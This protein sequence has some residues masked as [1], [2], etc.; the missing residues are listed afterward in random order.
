MIIALGLPLADPAHLEC[1]SR[2]NVSMTHTYS[3]SGMT[4]SGC[5][6]TVKR[7]IASVE[8][9]KNASISLEQSNAEI[10]MDTHIPLEKFQEALK[11]YQ[12]MPVMNDFVAV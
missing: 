8:H 7:V 2:E 11:P 4:C 9:V 12:G 1:E 10:V 6:A 5:A 3:I